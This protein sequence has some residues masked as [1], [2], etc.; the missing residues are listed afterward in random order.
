M[1]KVPNYPLQRSGGLA[2]LARRPLSVSVRRTGDGSTCPRATT[3]LETADIGSTGEQEERQIDQQPRHRLRPRWRHIR[4]T[5]G[6]RAAA[7]GAAAIASDARRHGR[8]DR[9]RDL[10]SD[11]RE[12]HA[13]D[14]ARLVPGGTGEARHR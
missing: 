8:A 1:G 5:R 13:A 2:L 12:T 6:G 9:P 11:A 10:L 7:E 4:A 14:G 3:S